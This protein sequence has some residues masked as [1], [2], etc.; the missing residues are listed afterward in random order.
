[1]QADPTRYLR[2]F[3]D[4]AAE[5]VAALEGALLR[6]ES[7]PHDPDAVDAAFRAAHSIKGGADAVG[8]P[9]IAKFTHALEG[10]LEGF[11]G[12]AKIPRRVLDLLLEAT[13]TLARLVSAAR[14]GEAPPPGTDELLA[15]L[16][17]KGSDSAAS[18]VA[19]EP[20]KA[21]D[22]SPPGGP[23]TFTVAITPHADALRSGLDPLPLLQELAALGSIERVELHTKALPPFAD[24]DPER[25]YLA[26]TVR[27][28]TDRPAS[29]ISDV[30]AF[31]PAL[32][33]A[34]VTADPVAPGSE[35]APPQPALSALGGVWTGSFE[36]RLPVPDPIRFATFLVQ[37]GAV[38]AEQALEALAR[39]HDARPTLG[40]VAVQTGRVSV[41]KLKGMLAQMGPGEGFGAAAVRLGHLSESDLGR[42]VL[43]QEQQAPPLG[44]CLCETGALTR[45]AL[46]A[47][48]ARYR[49]RAVAEPDPAASFCDLPL[50]I[51]MPHSPG[52]SLLVENGPMIGDFC[53]E[54]SD[55]LETADRNLLVIDGDPTNADALNAVYRGFHTIK[56]VSSML[57]LAAVQMLAHEA[58]N[59]LNLAREG[60]VRLQGKPMDLVFASTDALKRQVAFIRAWSNDGGKLPQDP[61]LPALLADLRAAVGG[62]PAAHPP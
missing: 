20:P 14:G 27:L 54:A 41:E 31:A 62:P 33:A 59:L 15:R 35:P 51:E 38:T 6:L 1:M 11:R 43:A 10:F 7:G 49:S 45:D 19:G 57:G 4:E 28:T 50:A 12:G 8:L 34:T 17:A 42:L 2:T 48:L 21:P 30:F 3:F 29:A 25:C 24:L 16:T 23:R 55:H 37:R 44:E 26:W 18:K 39:Q 9:H 40:R 22:R 60:K 53:V 47:E 56:G 61:A 58:E 36:V 32:I 5:H 13:D 46:S 52:A